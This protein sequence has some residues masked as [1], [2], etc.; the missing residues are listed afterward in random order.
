MPKQCAAR[1][2]EPPL[3]TGLAPLLRELV[4]LTDDLQDQIA[5]A[6][7]RAPA[8]PEQVP[9]EP[10]V[11]DAIAA[12]ATALAPGQRRWRL[13]PGLAGCALDADR[14]ALSQVLQRVLGNAARHSRAGDWI[15]VGLEAGPDGARAGSRGRGHRACVRR[16]ARRRRD[17]R[18][19]AASGWGWRWRGG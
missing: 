9:L 18:K 14:R 5:P 11:R 17:S 4:V 16:I 15:E 1:C 10:A 2:A 12:V 8:V 13:A 7:E 6:A 3:Q 19:V